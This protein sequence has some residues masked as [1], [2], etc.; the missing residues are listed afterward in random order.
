MGTKIKYLFFI[1]F[2]VGCTTNYVKDPN[3]NVLVT[4]QYEDEAPKLIFLDNDSCTKQID[5]AKK[6]KSEC[7][8]ALFNDSM[9]IIKSAKDLESRKL[10]LSAKLDYMI[11]LCRLI[12]VEI[13]INNAKADNHEN[14]L[15]FTRL[16]LEKNV[17]STINLCEKKIMV[18][19]FK[20]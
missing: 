17:K 13:I 9:Q 15:T 16:G 7:A 8:V 18:L 20:R 11:A 10:Y 3:A 12:E 19:D 4:S 1:L 6:S 14:W 5:C 2:L